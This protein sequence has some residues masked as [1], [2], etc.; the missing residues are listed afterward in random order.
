MIRELIEK[1]SAFG[2]RIRIVPIDHSKKESVALKTCVFEVMKN[3]SQLAPSSVRNRTI[4]AL[5]FFPGLR[6]TL[7]QVT[8]GKRVTAVIAHKTLALGCQGDRRNALRN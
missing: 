1:T 8:I 2:P 7:R 5:A 4:G 6:R 3:K